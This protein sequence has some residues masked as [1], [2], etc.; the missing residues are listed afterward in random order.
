VPGWGWAG[1]GYVGASGAWLRNAFSTGVAGH[2]VG[3]NFGLNH[4][5]YWDTSGA[6]V[7]GN[8]NS[9]EYGDSFD[10]MGSASA[11]ANHFNA[12]Y[13]RYLNWLQTGG[14]LS[15]SNSGTY[16]IYAHDDTNSTGDRKH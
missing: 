1:L 5:N 6:S 2:E 12:G 14:T 9:I 16:R 11:G 4:A 3:H 10:T 7:I 13:K 8:G 15:V